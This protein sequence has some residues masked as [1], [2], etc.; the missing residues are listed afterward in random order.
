[1]NPTTTSEYGGE[2]WVYKK[3]SHPTYVCMLIAYLKSSQMDRY[4][5]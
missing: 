1:M 5:R 3:V 4:L 2:M